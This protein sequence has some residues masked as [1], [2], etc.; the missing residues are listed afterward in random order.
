METQTFPDRVFK[1][2]DYAVSHRQMVIRSLGPDEGSA[3]LDL[4]FKGVDYV[5]TSAVFKGL[6]VVRPTEEEV[7]CVAAA[8]QAESVG[9][10]RVWVLESEG[11][12]HVVVADSMDLSETDFPMMST[13][14]I[15]PTG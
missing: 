9:A 5:S 7:V 12:R 3:N 4:H 8:M 14:L 1:I 6:S 15:H 11:I 2:W 13:A 10:E